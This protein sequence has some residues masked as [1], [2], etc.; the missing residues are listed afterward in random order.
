MSLHPGDIFC[1]GTPPGVAENMKPP[2]YLRGGETVVLGMEK[3]GVQ[4]HKVFKYEE[5]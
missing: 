4:E 2:R 1:T 5:L 3:L